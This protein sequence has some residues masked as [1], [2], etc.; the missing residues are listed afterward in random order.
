MLCVA[1]PG[2]FAFVFIPAL[3]IIAGYSPVVACSALVPV[4]V[5]TLLLSGAS[6]RLAQ[7]IGLRPPLVAGCL[8]CTVA[9][10]RRRRRRFLADVAGPAGAVGRSRFCR[11]HPAR[12]ASALAVQVPLARAHARRTGRILTS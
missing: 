12:R 11:L 7:R 1:P 9:S 10:I 2:G 3:E 5:V 6:G 4:T 8:V